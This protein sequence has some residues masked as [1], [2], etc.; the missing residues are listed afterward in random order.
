VKH[1]TVER[2]NL[3]SPFPE[4]GR[5]SN[6]GWGCHPTVTSLVGA[7]QQLTSPGSS[8]EG[9]L[10]LKEKREPRPVEK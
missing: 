9:I 4:E 5:T 8:L 7:G 6:E 3:Q 10:E 1:L 2:G